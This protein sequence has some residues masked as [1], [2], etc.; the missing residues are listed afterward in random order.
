MTIAISQ[1]HDNDTSTLASTLLC[2]TLVDLLSL[3]LVAKH[4]HWNVCGASFRSA[5]Q[6]FDELAGVAA[7]HSD[8]VAERA[9]TLGSVPNGLPARLSTAPSMLEV[10]G[11]R[12]EAIEALMLVEGYVLAIA[13]R[14]A[15]VASRLNHDPVST[16]LCIQIVS[17]LQRQAWMLRAHGPR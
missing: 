15:A 5:H 14:L 13:G 1:H 6:Q 16:D 12:L 2:E 4:A 8:R 11:G 10:P 17:D 3:Q 7:N 9:V